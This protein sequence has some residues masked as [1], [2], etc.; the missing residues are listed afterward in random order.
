MAVAQPRAVEEIRVVRPR[1]DLSSDDK[2][3]IVIRRPV[4]G[5]TGKGR[6]RTLFWLGRRVQGLGLAL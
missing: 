6:L 2:Q 1:P 3:D 4:Q 5:A